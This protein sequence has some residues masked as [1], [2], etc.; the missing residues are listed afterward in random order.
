MK[1][2]P[3]LFLCWLGTGFGALLG[4]I[5]GHGAGGRGLEA[6]AIIGG[7]LGLA[8]AVLLA[9]RLGWLPP[10]VVAG[11]LV[12]GWVGFGIAVPITLSH[13]QSPVVPVMS[14]ALAGV[15]ALFGAGVAR[16]LR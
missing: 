6:G 9:R 12:G 14:C 1:A 16:G 11:A 2:L 4:S 7:V 5:L 8:L 15:G 13:M 10:G 3:A